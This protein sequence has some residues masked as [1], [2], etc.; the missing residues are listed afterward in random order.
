MRPAEALRAGGR[1]VL[2]LLLPPTCLTCDVTVERPGQLCAACFGRTNFITAPHC[3]RCGVPFSYAAG[4]AVP[5]CEDCAVSPPLYDR[6]RAALLY[7]EQSRRIV[8][9]FKHSDRT[10]LAAALARHMARAGAALLREADLLVP[11]P[12]HRWRLLRRRYNQSAL[13]ARVLSR[14][15]GRP[16][17]LDGLV[18]LRPTPI[19]GTRDGLARRRIM[20]GAIAIR[21]HRAARVAGRRVL[22]IDD[23]LTTG[24]T[25]EACAQA[26]LAAGAVAVD[27]LAAARVARLAEVG[28]LF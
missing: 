22:L 17:L 8:L 20:A 6:A 9:A 26:L 15:T 2:D 3:P 7:D 5:P 25:A 27:V 13:L 24:A 4:G 28:L 10:E 23:V 16:A 14:Q 21:P 1:A 19:L 18:R 11:V 12:I